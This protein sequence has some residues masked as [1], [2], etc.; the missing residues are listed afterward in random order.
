MTRSHAEA[1]YPV[2]AEAARPAVRRERRHLALDR[3]LNVEQ[4]EPKALRGEDHVLAFA[5]C[6]EV[7]Q[8]IGGRRLFGDL[9]NGP[10]EYVALA[11]HRTEP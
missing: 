4:L 2:N 10:L 1:C 8:A 3:G 9:G 7:H 11:L 5:V 6:G